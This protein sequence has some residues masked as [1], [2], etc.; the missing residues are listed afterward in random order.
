[1]Y[2][3]GGVLSIPCGLYRHRGI[4]FP[5][6]Q[7][8][9]AS[10]ENGCVVLEPVE[11]FAGGKPVRRE[12]RK[13][14]FSEAEIVARGEDCLGKPYDLFGAN[15]DHLVAHVLG[16]RDGSPQLRNWAAVA[17]LVV[18]GGLAILG[19]RRA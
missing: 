18:L 5:D 14:R 4:A 15:C 3:T 13:S 19:K 16:R 12:T 9:H 11:V 8:L 1:M 17:G 2:Q 6:G 7:V 10:K